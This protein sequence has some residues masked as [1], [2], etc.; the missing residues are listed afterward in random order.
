MGVNSRAAVMD[1]GE[2][3]ELYERGVYTLNEA[4][5]A[6]VCEAA[7]VS[8]AELARDPPRQFIDAV[9]RSALA[10]PETATADDCVVINSSRAHAERWFEGAVNWKRYLRP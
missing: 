4:V 3:I 1:I 5:T 2:L 6:I 10:L 7:D 9:S 8:P